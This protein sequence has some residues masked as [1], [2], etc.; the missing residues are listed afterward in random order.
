MQ[1]NQGGVLSKAPSF[2]IRPMSPL[3][4]TP[5]EFLNRSKVGILFRQ[6]AEGCIHL[7]TDPQMITRLFAIAEQ[8]FVTTHVVIVNGLFPQNR[9]T[10]EKKFARRGGAA[11]LMQTKSPVEKSGAAIRRHATEFS[12]HPIGAPPAFALHEMMQ[13]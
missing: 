9:G 12:A 2:D 11:E 3:S 1:R 4:G 6:L 5:D 13:T 7:E 8:R 10:L